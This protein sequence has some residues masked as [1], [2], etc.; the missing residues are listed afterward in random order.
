MLNFGPLFFYDGQRALQCSFFFFPVVAKWAVLYVLTTGLKHHWVRRAHWPQSLRTTVSILLNSRFPMFLFWGPDLIQFYNDAYRPSLGEGGKH[1]TALGQKAVD[2][3]PEIWEDIQPMLQ[4]VLAGGE[5]TWS[6]DQLL[7]FSRNGQIEDIYWTFSYS[8]VRNDAGEI[9]GV[10]TV[11][12]ETTRKG[13]QSAT[14][15]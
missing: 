14:T 5:A 11:C 8:P 3:W 7:P 15:P 2:C 13:A 12:Q 1:P 9:G 4:Q 6:E 10:L